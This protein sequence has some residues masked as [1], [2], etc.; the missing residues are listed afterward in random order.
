MENL[1]SSNIFRAS[2]TFPLA[3]CEN[4]LTSYVFRVYLDPA[5]FPFVI[6]TCTN[7]NGEQVFDRENRQGGR[8]EFMRLDN[9]AVRETVIQ[10]TN[11]LGN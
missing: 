11:C 2:L 10:R 8:S 3:R 6:K 1:I 9:F 7:R 5:E 4:C